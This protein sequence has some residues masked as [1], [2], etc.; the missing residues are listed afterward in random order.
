MSLPTGILLPVTIVALSKHVLVEAAVESLDAAIAAERA[1]AERIELCARLDL[2]GTTPSSTLIEK[3]L[4]RVRIPV[5]VMVRPRKG[6]FVY[7]DDELALMTKDVARISR[8][9]PAGIVTGAIGADGQLHRPGLS[10]LVGAAGDLPTTFHRAF[11]ALADQP[12]A[13]EELIDIGFKRILTAGGASSALEGVKRIAVLVERVRERM[14]V[15]AG[16]GVRAHNVGEV[17]SR[18]GVR[19]VHAR[20]VDEEQMRSLVA[21]A[22]SV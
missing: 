17:I 21:A 16:G 20:Y 22:G 4:E 19:E 12:A 14:T 8:L 11:D 7:T 9:Q 1:G 2:G 3:V 13:I 5:V 18:T 10:R 15:I 6:G